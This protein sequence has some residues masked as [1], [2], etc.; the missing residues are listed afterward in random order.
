MTLDKSQL[1]E[2]PP[3]KAGLLFGIIVTLLTDEVPTGLHCCAPLD[4]SVGVVSSHLQI[5]I[6]PSGISAALL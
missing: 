3:D 5:Y 6:L 4:F 1:S 2:P